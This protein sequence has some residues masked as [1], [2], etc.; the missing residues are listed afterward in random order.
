MLDVDTDGYCGVH[1]ARRVGSVPPRAADCK[2]FLR[3]RVKIGVESSP[4]T[5]RESAPY[6]LA[7]MARIWEMSM[8]RRRAYS[9]PSEKSW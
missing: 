3:A 5:H 7:K 2:T 4:P 1:A 9:A 8:Q 6:C